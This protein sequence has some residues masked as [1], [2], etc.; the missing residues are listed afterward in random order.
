MLCLSVCPSAGPRVA[1]AVILL[2]VWSARVG[3]CSSV[4]SDPAIYPDQHRWAGCVRP[5]IC[6]I[7]DTNT[8]ST[9]LDPDGKRPDIE[10]VMLDIISI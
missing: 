4:V 8:V 3:V 6:S 5:I 10:P 2:G 7:P 1:G 9:G